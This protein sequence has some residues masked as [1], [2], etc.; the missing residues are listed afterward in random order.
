MTVKQARQN[1]YKVRVLHIRKL[2][3][4]IYEREV[5]ETYITYPA[6]SYTGIDP[7]GGKVIVEI[8]SP[9]G[10]NACG[11]AYC[12]PKMNYNKKVLVQIALQRALESI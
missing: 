10:E 5:P 11:I 2:L 4:K 6:I 8:T 9:L 12:H 7:R 1:G 3:Y